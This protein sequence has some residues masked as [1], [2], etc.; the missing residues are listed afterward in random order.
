M[1]TKEAMYVEHNI[2]EHSRNHCYRLKAMSVTYFFVYVCV[3]ACGCKG[4]GFLFRECILTYPACNAPPYFSILSHKRHD[5]SKKATECQMF[6]L[7]FS[8]TFISNVFRSEKH[9]AIYWYNLQH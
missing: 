3:R 8:T 7:I 2:E 6:V 9:L 4:A 5:F 1:N